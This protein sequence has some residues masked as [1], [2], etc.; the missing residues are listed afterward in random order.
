MFVKAVHLKSCMSENLLVG[1]TMFGFATLIMKEVIGSRNCGLAFAH[2]LLQHDP[3]LLQFPSPRSAKVWL[4]P[5]LWFGKV[6]S[7]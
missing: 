3:F 1:R 4:F 2:F 7:D 5:G 6:A